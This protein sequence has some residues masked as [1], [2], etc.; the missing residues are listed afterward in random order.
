[1]VGMWKGAMCS[2]ATREKG[3]AMLNELML[4]PRFA[5]QTFLSL[6]GEIRSSC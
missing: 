1:M 2:V 3:R 5:T 4:N 6:V